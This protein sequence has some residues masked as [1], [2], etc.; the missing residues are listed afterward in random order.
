MRTLS[1]AVA[2]F[3]DLELNISNSAAAKLLAEYFDAQ[4]NLGVSERLSE[5]ISEE[6]AWSTSS[7]WDNGYSLA[8]EVLD[9][10]DPDTRSASTRIEVLLESLGIVVKNVK[11][12]PLGPRG[13][14]FA[15]SDLR[16]K[17]LV[18]IDNLKNKDKSEFGL[19]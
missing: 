19:P 17:I 18:N 10:A 5:L 1:P 6:P 9:E 2:M 4:A 16:P 15:G 3:G 11:L 12:G 7:P 13:V 8:L 14:A